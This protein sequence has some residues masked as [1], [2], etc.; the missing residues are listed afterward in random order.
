M[1]QSN[2]DSEAVSIRPQLESFEK[3]L[4]SIGRS[5]VTGWRWRQRGWIEVVNIAGRPYVTADAVTKFLAR[6]ENGEFAKAKDAMPINT[7]QLGTN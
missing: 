4:R 3:F 7:N 5:R 1:K 2:N 6:A